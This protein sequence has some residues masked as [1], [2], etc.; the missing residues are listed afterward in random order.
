M[1]KT[2]WTVVAGVAIVATSL[3]VSLAAYAGAWWQASISLVGTAA[4]AIAV[5]I[6]ADAKRPRVEVYG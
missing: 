6:L 2:V 3:G 4:L 5:Y 1:T